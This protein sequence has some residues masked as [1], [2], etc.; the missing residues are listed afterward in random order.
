MKWLLKQAQAGDMV[1]VKLGS[2][3]HYGV[4]ASEDEIIQFGLAPSMRSML[5]DSEIEVC[6]SDVDTFLAGGFLEVAVFERGEKK[7]N[8]PAD[9]ALD[10]AR[11]RIGERGYSILYNNC[12]HFAYECIT[13]STYCSQTA[14]VR[15]FFKALPIADVYI[16]AIPADLEVTS[17]EP[18]QKNA[19]LKKIDDPVEREQSYF[20][21]R[22][23]E[24][25]LERTF[26]YRI[27]KLRYEDGKWVSDKCEYAVCVRDGAVAVAVS[28]GAIDVR[29]AQ[30]ADALNLNLTAT[31]KIWTETVTLNGREYVF[32]VATDTPEVL[33][34]YSYINLLN[35]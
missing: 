3:Y 4:F 31:T 18:T 22:L 35:K 27:K 15:A 30:S 32:S 23:L 17:V 16:A 19:Q 25:A 34:I 29:I 7:K 21:W 20:A 8:R 6:I 13:G 28:R 12:E 14:D 2:I 11:S 33:R 26:G 10:Y 9:E 5:K 1:R 24:Y